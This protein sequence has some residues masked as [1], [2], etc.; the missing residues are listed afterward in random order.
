MRPLAGRAKHRFAQIARQPGN[1]LTDV[2]VVQKAH[3][4][5][6]GTVAALPRRNGSAEQRL[7]DVHRAV[8]LTGHRRLDPELFERFEIRLV[9]IGERRELFDKCQRGLIAEMLFSCE[10]YRSA[11]RRPKVRTRQREVCLRAR[12]I[13]RTGQ[14]IRDVG[15][16]DVFALGEGTLQLR[17]GHTPRFAPVKISFL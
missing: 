7:K 16:P 11:D 14:E 9:H 10:A 1:R 15:L 12:A 6:R 5:L 4:V 17:D 8:Q 2:D 3:A 13:V